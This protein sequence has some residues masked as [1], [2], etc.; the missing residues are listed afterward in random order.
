M[1]PFWLLPSR[2]SA[3]QWSSHL[4]QHHGTNGCCTVPGAILPCCYCSD[5]S[6]L[7][8]FNLQ[9]HVLQDLDGCCSM[10]ADSACQCCRTALKECPSR[11]TKVSVI[12]TLCTL[13]R[14]GT[15]FVQGAVLWCSPD[16]SFRCHVRLDV[17]IKPDV[18]TGTIPWEPHRPAG[19]VFSHMIPATESTM[20]DALACPLCAHQCQPGSASAQACCLCAPQRENKP[21]THAC[22]GGDASPYAVSATWRQNAEQPWHFPTADLQERVKDCLTP[23]A[24]HET[25]TAPFNLHTCFEQ[26]PNWL[27]VASE[28]PPLPPSKP[29]MSSVAN[30]LP[31][32]ETAPLSLRSQQKLFPCLPVLPLSVCHGIWNMLHDQEQHGLV[33]PIQILSTMTSRPLA[34]CPYYVVP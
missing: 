4:P 8:L 27:V 16:P 20:R 29:G 10:P 21:Q 6:I 15:G 31:R 13:I 12:S 18:L 34:L 19:D 26:L 25:S 30:A 33:Q 24:K 32:P 2:K 22:E 9:D 23:P 3:A 5:C 14:S 17:Y 1:W 28:Y 11:A 7:I